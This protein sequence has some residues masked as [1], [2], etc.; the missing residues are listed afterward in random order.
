ML[1]AGRCIARPTFETPE[2]SGYFWPVIAATT[3]AFFAMVGFE[4]SV[5][6]AEECKEP[7][8]LFP[9]VLLTG[10]AITG[11]VYVLVS[12]SAITLVSAAELGEGDTPLLKVIQAGAPG[13]PI[14]VFALITMF[15]VAN[16]ALINMMMASRLIYGMAREGVVPDVLGKVHK[17]PHAT[18]R[19]YLHFA[20]GGWPYSVCRWCSSARRYDRIIASLCVRGGQCRSIGFA[21]RPCRSQAFPHT[22][23]SADTGC[24]QLHIPCRSLDRTRYGTIC[25]CRCA[26]RHWRGA[27]VCNSSLYARRQPACIIPKLYEYDSW[28]FG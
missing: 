9:K 19:D 26:A 6:M 16:S 10:L 15:A 14:G 23:D 28:S 3:L 2:G 18:Y 22:H 4:D 21:Q 17:S 13:F 8:R 25:N 27:V 1:A 12:I 7:S 20:A 5:N 11:I 24:N